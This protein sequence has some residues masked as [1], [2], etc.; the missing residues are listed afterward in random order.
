MAVLKSENLRTEWCKGCRYCVESCPKGALSIG[1]ELNK[2]GFQ[3][4][5]LDEALC[6]SCGTCRIVC[7]DCVFRFVEEESK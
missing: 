6:V 2:S 5:V 1:T 3:Y 4:V 7:P